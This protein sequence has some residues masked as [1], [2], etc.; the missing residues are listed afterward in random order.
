[1]RAQ[2]LP[3]ALAIYQHGI[4]I[5]ATFEPRAP[6]CEEWDAKH[7]K[8]CRLVAE[9][10]GEVVGFVAL[11]GASSRY[12]Y[13]GVAEM[14]CYVDPKFAGRGIGE[15]LTRA[16]IDES[17]RQGIWTLEAKIVEGNT[18]S[19]RLCEKCGFRF[20]GYRAR[21]GYDADGVWKDILIYERRSTRAELDDLNT[22]E[23]A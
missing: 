4:D 23:G 1:M 17:E 18:A 3:R 12:V 15:A 22:Y 14:S 9:I 2:D 6:S 13:R 5:K 16:L 7:L 8:I 21:M 11:L 20:V 19:V 10:D